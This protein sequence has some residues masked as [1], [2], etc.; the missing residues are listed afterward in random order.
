M[1]SRTFCASSRS[2]AARV[3]QSRSALS[4]RNASA[5]S[6]T[7]PSLERISLAGVAWSTPCRVA[8]ARAEA[9]SPRLSIAFRPTFVGEWSNCISDWHGEVR[10]E[11][12]GMSASEKRD[13]YRDF[14]G[15]QVRAILRGS[16]GGGHFWSWFH[17]NRDDIDTLSQWDMKFAIEQDLIPGFVR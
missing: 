12:D 11:V 13:M 10:S 1:P 14:G 6:R 15:Q 8:A 5:V 7:R 9:A 4:S 17:P 3:L 2:A 16:R